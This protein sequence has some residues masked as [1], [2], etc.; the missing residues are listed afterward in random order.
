MSVLHLCT[1][2]TGE[3]CAV[4]ARDGSYSVLQRRSAVRLFSRKEQVCQASGFHH[5]FQ[6]FHLHLFPKSYL[7]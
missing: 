6:L 7:W 1:I 3:M 5:V 4:C 2:R